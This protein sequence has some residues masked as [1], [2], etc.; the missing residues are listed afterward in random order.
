MRIQ[1]QNQLLD[2]IPSIKKLEKGDEKQLPLEQEKKQEEME[3][4]SKRNLN[5]AV[6][7]SKKILDAFYEMQKLVGMIVDE[8][9]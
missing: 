1:T 2:T 9:I 6:D 4:I 7:P 3:I 5:Q 8:K